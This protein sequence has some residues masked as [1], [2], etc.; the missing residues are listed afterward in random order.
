MRLA[1]FDLDNTLLA[2]DSDVTWGRFLAE[3]GAVD[4]QAYTRANEAFYEQYVAGTLDIREFCRF[5]FEPL[6]RHPL[7][8]LERWRREFIEERIRPMIA[9][10]TPALLEEHRRAGHTLLIITATNRF[11]TQP[12]A[13]L[14]RVPHLLATD[15]EFR[16]GRY[17]GEIAGTPCFQEGKIQRL[18]EWLREQGEPE[19]RIGEAR[20]YSDSRNDIPLLEAVAEPVAVD[21]DPALEAH[22]EARGWP[23]ISLRTPATAERAPLAGIA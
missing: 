20:F 6:V 1:L 11:V 22:A 14:L 13:E 21:A 15:P 12:I 5:V 7:P 2:G 3:V 10:G 19:E 8:V 17:T 9:P 4:A 18:Q 23:R 16:D